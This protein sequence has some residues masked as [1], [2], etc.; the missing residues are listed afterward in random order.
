MNNINLNIWF[1]YVSKGITVLYHRCSLPGCRDNDALQP[2]LIDFNANFC[3]L[4]NIFSFIDLDMPVQVSNHVYSLPVYFLIEELIKK[5]LMNIKAFC[6]PKNEQK[7]IPKQK[8]W[9]KRPTIVL[10]LWFFPF[11]LKMSC[12]SCCAR[13]ML[14]IDEAVSMKYGSRNTFVNHQMRE[15]LESMMNSLLL[16]HLKNAKT[17]IHTMKTTQFMHI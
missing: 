12:H 15:I 10:F 2:I 3:V 5:K 17:T 9:L 1:W 8:L 6:K 7:A 11:V 13:K 4:N 16:K 14:F